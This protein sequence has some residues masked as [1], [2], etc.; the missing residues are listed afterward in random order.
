MHA[1]AR[2]EGTRSLNTRHDTSR[3]GVSI[4]CNPIGPCQDITNKVPMLAD[5]PPRSFAGG[6]WNKR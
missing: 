5:Y 4:K 2:H 1:Q 3:H 6:H